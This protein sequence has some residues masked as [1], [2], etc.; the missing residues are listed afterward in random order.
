[1]AITTPQ[2]GLTE[3]EAIV[4][5]DPRFR[6]T[7]AGRL[8]TRVVTYLSYLLLAAFAATLFIS[9]IMRFV[10]AGFLLLLFLVD[11]VVHRKEGDVPIPES[12]RTGAVNA[13]RAFSTSAFGV[14]ERAFDRSAITKHNFYLEV[15]NRLL[16]IPEIKEGLRRLDVPPQEFKD[17][18]DDLLTHTVVDDSSRKSYGAAMGTLGAKAFQT[19]AA[20]GHRFVEP[21]DLFAA[22]VTVQDGAAE[23]LFS[24]FSIESGDLERALILSS[25]AHELRRRLPRVL[26]GFAPALRRG[27]RHRVMNRAWTSRPTPMLDRYGDDLTDRARQSQAGFL[28]GHAEEYEKV[29]EALARPI[30]PN[31]LLVGEAGIGK[32]TIIEH[33]AFEL[34]KDEVPKA[35]FDRRLVSLEI[36]SLVSGAAPEE[37][38]ARIAKIAEEIVTA[39]NVIL[40]I[41]DIHNLVK[42]SSTAYLS[43]ADALMPIVMNDAFP[44]LGTTYP[45]EFKQFIEPRSDFAGAF[46]IIQVNEI[47]I[48][49]AETVLAYQSVI[50][51]RNTGIIISFGAVKRAVV[52][53]KKYLTDKFLPSSA[54]DLL[55]SALVA[56]EQRGEKTLGPDLVTSVTEAKVHIPLHGAGDAEAQQL[57]HLEDFIHERLVGQ[58]EAVVAIATALREYRSGLARGA[59]PIASFLFVGP[60]GVGKTE[61]AKI[62]AKVQFGSENMMIRFD[63]TE[64][65]DKESFIR[66]IGSP[67]GKTSG[68]LTEAVRAKPYSLILLDEFEKAFPDILNLFLQVFD[69][70][71]LTD[72]LGR[73]VD[74]A[75]TIIIATS[76]AHSDI[77]N[78]ALAKGETMTDIEGYLKARLTDVFKP[79]LLNRFS[80]I[81]LFR[82]LMPVDLGHIVLL[83]LGDLAE[84]VKAQGIFLDFDPAAVAEIAKLG[85]D[86]SFGARPLRRVID[87]KIKSPL[88]S[89]ILAKTIEKGNRIKLVYENDAFKFLPVE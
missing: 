48:P 35:L 79:E 52:L 33:L 17:K 13:A 11:R 24:L 46:E 82:D 49:E 36:Q 15:A 19:A 27:I 76:N 75:N 55:K 59:G 58:D 44:V 50:L 89:A 84:T 53:A 62:L 42:S 85:Y 66:F 54:E 88:A 57:L 23:R 70:G 72:N 68:A 51:E 25:V 60:T 21:A 80:K 18:L 4:F 38:S 2:K 65:Q 6:M 77:I 22:L 56:A 7:V 30:K 10:M 67:D 28:V 71:R 1:M 34:T 83:N 45:R 8:F 9:G 63:M 87:E 81:V 5:D 31:A 20:A 43:A 47:G 14:V 64:Y 37:L 16:D 39:G 3:N 61:L 32:G 40:C 73:T 29:V 69:D 74:F 26:G 12:P 41:P 86:P 78:D